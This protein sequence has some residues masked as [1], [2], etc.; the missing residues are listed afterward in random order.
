MVKEGGERGRRGDRKAEQRRREERGV[1]SRM[2]VSCVIN[3]NKFK[4]PISFSIL[5]CF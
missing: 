2:A 5:R 1:C 3:E 4:D